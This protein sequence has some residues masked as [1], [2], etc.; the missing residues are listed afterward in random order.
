MKSWTLP[1]RT[2]QQLALDAKR[3]KLVADL[4]RTR[5]AFEAG[6]R[7]CQYGETLEEAWRASL[8]GRRP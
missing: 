2:P 6:Y 4:N 8:E 7:A 3:A 1:P 5:V